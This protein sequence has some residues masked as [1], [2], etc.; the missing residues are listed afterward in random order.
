MVCKV[1]LANLIKPLTLKLFESR[2]VVPCLSPRTHHKVW[3]ILKQ[4][5][6]SWCTHFA[7]HHLAD[8][9]AF[10]NHFADVGTAP[11]RAKQTINKLVSFDL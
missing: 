8:L 3:G 10:Y 4:E 9:I 6:C 1:R 2:S 7:V 11:Q 5:T